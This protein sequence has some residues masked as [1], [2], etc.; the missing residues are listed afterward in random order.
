[1]TLSSQTIPALHLKNPKLWWP[2]GYGLPNLYTCHLAFRTGGEISDQ[3]SVTF[4]I[5][6]YTYDT[7]NGILHIH[8]NGVR[9]F[10]K[11]G[12]WGMSEFMLR[13]G[14]K[15]YDTKVRFHKELNFNMIRNWMGMTPR[16]SILRGL[17]QI[18]HHGL[19]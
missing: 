18:R 8:I 9:V 10:P 14:A 11:G 12:S 16:R 2:N 15:D 7:D 13:C 19:G 1:M 3:K 17:R 4:G 6:K 5:K